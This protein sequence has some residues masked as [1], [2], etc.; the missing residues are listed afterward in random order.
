MSSLVQRIENYI[1]KL[2]NQSDGRLRVR[3]RELADHFKCVPSQINYVLKTRFTIER[4]YIVESQRGG[5][6][7][8]EIR[9]LVFDHPEEDF[10]YSALELIGDELSQQQALNLIHNLEERKILTKR[11][12]AI[13]QSMLHRRNLNIELPYRDYLRARLLKAAL[14]AI[15]KTDD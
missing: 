1:K 12:S 7:F 3:R 13:L 6:G 5:G 11:E 4:G 9:K 2:L 15:M 14:G 8:I 10:L